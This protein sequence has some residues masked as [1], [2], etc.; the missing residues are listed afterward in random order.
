MIVHLMYTPPKAEPVQLTELDLLA[1]SPGYN[2]DNGTEYFDYEDG[3]L[4]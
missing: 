4:I 1:Q 3:G 2:E